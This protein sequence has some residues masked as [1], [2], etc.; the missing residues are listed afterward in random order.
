MCVC[1]CVYKGNNPNEVRH[2]SR[3]SSSKECVG[4]YIGT[5]KL[6]EVQQ[7]DQCCTVRNPEGCD[8]VINLVHVSINRRDQCCHDV[9][10][11]QRA[12][13]NANQVLKVRNSTTFAYIRISWEMYKLSCKG[14]SCVRA[15]V[16]AV[17]VCMCA[18]YLGPLGCI[19]NID[20]PEF[21][22]G[23]IIIARQHI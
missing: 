23:V 15:C 5:C 11:V 8:Y 4:P 10:D 21:F 6:R 12:V 17:R 16:R 18:R 14:M 20:S 3:S 1:V 2:S 7:V 13:D 9:P 22:D 19:P